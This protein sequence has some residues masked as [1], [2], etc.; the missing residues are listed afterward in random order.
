M[1]RIALLFSIFLFQHSL[2]ADK[3][4]AEVLDLSS[5]KLTLPTDNQRQ[6][7]ADEISVE[8]LQTFSH[9]DFFFI[10]ADADG[11]LFRAPC[12]GKTTKGSKYPRSELREMENPEKRAAW[13]TD[14]KM[15]HVMT[16]KLAI[17]QT[18]AKKKHV[19]CAQIHD[20]TDDV[21]MVRLEGK[22]LFIE[23]N[24]LKEIPLDNDYQ[25]GTPF[26]IKIQAG[27]GK[28][29]LWHNGTQKLDWKKFSNGCYFK[30]GCYTQSNTDRGDSPDSYGEVLIQELKLSHQSGSEP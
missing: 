13:S 18:P 26:E 2:H 19:V 9:P 5:W 22:K 10:N 4:P 1:K 24:D 8:D 15:L 27:Q 28:I 17:T 20:K 6:G 3:L 7:R 30:A 14:D 11:V 25:L 16:L 21:L 12:R 23:R 29:K